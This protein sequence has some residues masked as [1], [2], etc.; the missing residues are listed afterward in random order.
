V[1][2][3]HVVFHGAYSEQETCLDVP[4]DLYD[5]DAD[6]KVVTFYSADGSTGMSTV[7]DLGSIR[8]FQGPMECE[9]PMPDPVSEPQP[10]PEPVPET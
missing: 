8:Y 4:G 10:T 2:M 3:F 5:F 7:V 9:Y 1:K 6:E